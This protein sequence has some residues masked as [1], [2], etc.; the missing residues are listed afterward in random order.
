MTSE[1]LP[2]TTQG[3]DERREL[4]LMKAIGFDKLSPEQREIALNIASRYDLDPLLR[5]VVLVDGK[6]FIT[7]DGLLWVAHRSG[8]FAGI[9]VTTPVKD[10]RFWRATATV[11]RKDMPR[12]FVYPGRYPVGSKNDEEMCIK[13][14]ESMALRRAFNVAAPTLD[15]RWAGDDGEVTVP[16]KPKGMSL[17]EVAR[18]KAAEAAQEAPPAVEVVE[19]ESVPSVC[20]VQAEDGLMLGSVCILD[21]DHKGVHKSA[22]GSWPR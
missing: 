20:G 10:D 18:A 5:H 11:W 3:T 13:V 14:A 9:E 16:D 19:V 1:H 21:T 12:P 4:A 15:E 17:A 8:V 7:R 22:D 6:P 2:A